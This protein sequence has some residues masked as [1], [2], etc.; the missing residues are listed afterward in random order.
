MQRRW[1][2]GSLYNDLFSQSGVPRVSR[3]ECD[4]GT[5]LAF[6]CGHCPGIRNKKPHFTFLPDQKTFRHS[7][8]LPRSLKSVDPGAKTLGSAGKVLIL[9]LIFQTI[10]L[11][12]SKWNQSSSLQYGICCQS[13]QRAFYQNYLRS[14]ECPADS[15]CSAS[16]YWKS[17]FHWTA[18]LAQ[19]ESLR[20]Q[21]SREC[22]NW[23]V[24]TWGV[25]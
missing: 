16:I 11:W 2:L 14:V 13:L 25:R 5:Q 22:C 17:V 8:L 6:C 12:P 20:G 21:S 4:N 23:R 3:W 7:F 9:F 1:W 18:T 24:I 10:N 19:R 15:S